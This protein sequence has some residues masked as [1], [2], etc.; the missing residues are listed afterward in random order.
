MKTKKNE[1]K[2]HAILAMNSQTNE[3][4]SKVNCDLHRE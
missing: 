1:L 2:S 4:K 3:G